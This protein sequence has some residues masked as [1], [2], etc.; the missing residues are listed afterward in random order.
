MSKI[1]LRHTLINKY[2]DIFLDFFIF[3]QA[4]THG[5]LS[6]TY[7]S[8]AEGFSLITHKCFQTPT[9]GRLK[10]LVSL[11]ASAFRHLLTEG[12]GLRCP[13]T[14]KV[15]PGTYLRKNE[16]FS[17]I[18]RKCVPIT[19]YG[20]PRVW[21]P[22]HVTDFSHLLTE[23]W[24]FESHYTKAFLDT[25]LRQAG[26]FI[27]YI[28]IRDS[29]KYQGSRDIAKCED[30]LQWQYSMKMSTSYCVWN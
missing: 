13:M 27:V 21:V 16:G 22:L 26:D 3:I 9:Y 6:D 15:F 20:M 10:V 23:G 17:P 28:Y 30:N 29:S 5:R 4:P 24:R 8:K 11:R 19:T 25:Y 2:P 7:F 12:W 14:R 1:F 18:T